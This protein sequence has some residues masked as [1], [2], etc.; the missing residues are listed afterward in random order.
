MWISDDYNDDSDN[1]LLLHYYHCVMH[2]CNH[3]WLTLRGL[4]LLRLLQSSA[5]HTASD[6]TCTAITFSIFFFFLFLVDA[7][8]FP[9]ACC[10]PPP[11][12]FVATGAQMWAI[13]VSYANLLGQ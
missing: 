10:P 3:P 11:F 5:H 7:A 1:H 12:F 2:Y 8:F 9:L 6:S 13:C 4:Q